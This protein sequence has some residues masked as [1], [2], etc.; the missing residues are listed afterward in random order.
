MLAAGLTGCGKKEDPASN[1]VSETQKAA[2]AAGAALQNAA[3]A[4]KTTADTTAA[5]ATAKAQELIDKAKALV[6]EKKY[7]EALAALKQV[8]DF[9]LSPEQQKLVDDLKTTITTAMGNSAA[10]NLP[11]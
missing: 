5:S 4:A 11:K 9:K 6:N 3:D 10:G 2:G 7:Q 8:A 1:A